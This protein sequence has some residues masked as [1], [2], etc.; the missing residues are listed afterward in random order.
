[1]FGV[2]VILLQ[3]FRLEVERH[4]VAQVEA[5]THAVVAAVLEDA[6]AHIRRQYAAGVVFAV[7]DLALQLETGILVVFVLLAQ[8]RTFRP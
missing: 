8:C 2:G 4:G 3:A 1:M 5:A 6:H 7:A